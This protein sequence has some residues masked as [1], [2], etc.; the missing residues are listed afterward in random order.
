MVQGRLVFM[1]R[2]RKGTVGLLFILSLLLGNGC[3]LL[4]GL[5]FDPAGLPCR[6][7]TAEDS[8]SCLD[9][10]TCVDNTCVA[11]SAKNA[12]QDCANDDECEDGLVCRDHYYFSDKEGIY[13]CDD[14][15]SSLNCSL[16]QNL[17][18]LG[19]KCRVIC[20][21]S[22]SNHGD[23]PKGQRCFSD[24]DPEISGYCQA[25]VCGRSIADCGGN[26]ICQ[27]NTN[28]DTAEST[29]GSGLCFQ[30]CDPLDCPI[31]N[32]ATSCGDCPTDD[33]LNGDEIP[34]VMG[35]EPH[36]TQRAPFVCIQSGLQTTGQ[37]CNY[38][39]DFCAP[40]NYCLV[41]NSSNNSGRCR[42]YC[43][44]AGGAPA[45]SGGATCN[46]MQN[47]DGQFINTGYCSL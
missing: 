32:T 36:D 35:C 14:Y 21:P 16:G 2:P 23:C 45:C 15:E 28:D 43:D 9:G 13:N 24:L 5:S 41:D 11:A 26:R 44:P 20:N 1:K 22:T 33:D 42:Q 12:G 31:N 6:T 3:T 17:F 27:D 25:G 4:F 7:P 39:N 38:S 18:S 29:G 47:D 46:Q 8:R 40:G 34:E 10:Y 37:S 30:E 19:A